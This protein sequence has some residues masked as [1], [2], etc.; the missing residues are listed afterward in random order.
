ML[1]LAQAKERPARG[2]CAHFRYRV[3]SEDADEL[4]AADPKPWRVCDTIRRR[5]TQVKWLG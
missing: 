3:P 2:T 1:E 4:R 5:T